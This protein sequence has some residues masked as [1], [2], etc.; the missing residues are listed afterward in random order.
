MK[1][2]SIVVVV[3]AVGI[4][5][6]LVLKP[7]SF[8]AR[9][10]PVGET[11]CIR[12]QTAPDLALESV[13]ARIV[14]LSDFQGKGVLLHFWATSWLPCRVEMQWFEQMHNQYGPQGLQVL[15]IAM[16]NADKKDIAEFASNLGV[17]Y[18][19]L[20]GK[21]SVGDSYGG[22]KVLPVTVYV[23][24][25]GK[26]VEKGGARSPL[27]CQIQADIYGHEVE[28]VDAEEGAA[29]GA[30][31]LAGVANGVWS[32]VEE[33]CEC[34]VHIATR[35]QPRPAV[36]NTMRSQYQLYRALYPALKPTF[37]KLA[38]NESREI[39]N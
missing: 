24:R 18:P 5:A 28:I 11:P 23:G 35:V 26:I 6:L 8:Q 27:W 21:E 30:A 16:V 2:A 9:R 10:A 29:Y 13:D 38:N 36:V 31:L 15:G 19:I 3:I 25:D 17:D 4:T 22:V 12:G 33:A 32:S 34:A 14:H 1:R 39:P 37:A 20:L 7:R